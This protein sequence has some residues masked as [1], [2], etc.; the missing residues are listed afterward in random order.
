[1]GVKCDLHT[2]LHLYTMSYFFQ[3]VNEDLGIIGINELGYE[4]KLGVVET[5]AD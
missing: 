1:M 4:I 3:K 2:N 5:V